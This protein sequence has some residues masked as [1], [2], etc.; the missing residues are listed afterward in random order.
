[1]WYSDWWLAIVYTTDEIEANRLT[2]EEEL[3]G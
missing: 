2:M 3:D 1:M